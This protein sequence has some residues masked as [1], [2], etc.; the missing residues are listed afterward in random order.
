MY[1]L[2]LKNATTTG[3]LLIFYCCYCFF[4]CHLVTP[5]HR[6]QSQPQVQ[7]SVEPQMDA[8]LL[9]IFQSVYKSLKCD[10][11]DRYA[12]AHCRKAL[13]LLYGM[14]CSARTPLSRCSTMSENPISPSPA[15]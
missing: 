12:K 5:N 3:L 4:Y 11:E 13:T 2:P 1:N 9:F 8:P 14:Q 7:E 15:T 6:A 10:I